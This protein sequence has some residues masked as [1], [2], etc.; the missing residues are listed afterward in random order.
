MLPLMTEKQPLPALLRA[1]VAAG[2]VIFAAG[3]V[4]LQALEAINPKWILPL[5]LIWAVMTLIDGTLALAL[6]LVTEIHPDGICVFF[7]PLGFP[8][9][10]FDWSEI[11]RLYPRTYSPIIEYGGWGIRWGK[12]GTAY[13]LRGNQG[14]QL[15]LKN[16][17][18]FLVGS[19]Y[20]DKLIE[21]IR[22]VAPPALLSTDTNPT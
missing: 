7:G 4:T 9:K 21:S 20:P 16:G 22:S 17:K 3:I 5:W 15:E 2:C 8:S 12:S 13:N 14:L 10:R 18:R 1:V 19:Q 6:K 11:A